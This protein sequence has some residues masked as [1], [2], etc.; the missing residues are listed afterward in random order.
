MKNIDSLKYFLEKAV[1]ETLKSGGLDVSKYAIAGGAIRDY[2]TGDKIKDI[3]IFCQDKESEEVLLK[4]LQEKYI[5]L[6][7]N[8]L[9][10]NFTVNDRWIQVI[11]GKYGD[12]STDDLIKSFDFTICGAMMRGN[13]EFKFLPTFFQDC[14]AKHLRING[15]PFPL[16]TL[17]RMQKYI[18]KGI[19]HAMELYSV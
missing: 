7:E 17:E 9:L 8:N 1:F 3:D 4:Y 6:N 14:L 13:G 19:R 18:K 5:L 12:L 10:G 11:K 16:S 15:I 2:L